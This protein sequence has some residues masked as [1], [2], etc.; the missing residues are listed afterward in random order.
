M[1]FRRHVAAVLLLL[2][3]VPAFGQGALLQGGPWAPGHAPMYVGSGSGQAIVQDSGPASGGPIGVGLSELGLTARGTGTP[4]YAG[5]G[6]GPFGAN[7]CDYDAPINNATGYHFLCLSANA[8]GG[9]LLAY[10]AGGIAAPLPFNFNINGAAYTFPFVTGGIVGP[11]TSVVGD[12]ACWN[13][14]TGTLLKDCGAVPA[15]GSA[16]FWTALNSFTAGITTPG[17]PPADFYVATTGSDSNTCLTALAP[18]LTWQAGWNKIARSNYGIGGAT[19]HIA[20]GFYSEGVLINQTWMGGGP[21]A[22]VGNCGTPGN[23]VVTTNTLAGAVTVQGPQVV[24]ISCF[25]VRSTFEHG[26]YAKWG[27]TIRHSNMRF[28]TVPDGQQTV[29]FDGTIVIDG[30]YAIVGSATRHAYVHSGAIR[31]QD[32]PITVTLI[33][34]PAFTWFAY[35]TKGSYFT[36]LTTFSGSAAN[37]TIRFLVAAN[38]VMEGDV[39]S[40]AFPGNVMLPPFDGGYFFGPDTV[41]PVAQANGIGPAYVTADGVANTTPATATVQQWSGCILLRAQG[42]STA[43][44]ASQ[45]SDWCVYNQTSSATPNTLGRLLFASQVNG[46]GFVDAMGLTPSGFLNVGG[47]FIL[48]GKVTQ[49]ATAPTVASGFCTSPSISSSNGTAAFTILIGSACA[50]TTGVLTMPAVATTGWACH[51]SNV[52]NP[53][54]S[55]PSQTASTTSTVSVKNYVRT[56]GVAGNWTAADTI[57][58]ACTGY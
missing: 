5:Q 39:A 29:S 12:V 55:T 8:Q 35:I 57:V 48:N 23:V 52:T 37:G 22:I 15:L 3:A 50:A 26:I 2:S 49:G 17:V 16:N 32:T 58:A 34:N 1:N 20:D 38:G 6:T 44:V 19:L 28:G 53:D 13:N 31:A 51:F 14:T 43:A 30:S 47:G 54:S 24:S 25:E 40:T 42:W 41:L 7:V 36:Y 46:A 27:G 18:C 45:T 11:S 9:G 21:V 4:P 10:G 56:T 33:G